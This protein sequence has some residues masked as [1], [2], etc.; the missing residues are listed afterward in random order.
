MIAV[1]EPDADAAVVAL[2]RLDH[3][4]EFR[5]RSRRRLLDQHVLASLDGRQTQRRQ[6]LVGRRDNDD[7][8]VVAEDGI[9]PPA[10]GDGSWYARRH[11]LG[12]LRKR[13]RTRDESAVDDARRS[14]A[15]DQT[16]ADESDSRRIA[17]RSPQ[18]KPRS[19]G[20]M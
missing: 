20:T 11:V 9:L 7:V 5:S 3:S 19:F 14:L 6:G 12:A 16:A 17:H 13:V 2:R 15:A 1:I 4:I 8:N 10:P 18:V